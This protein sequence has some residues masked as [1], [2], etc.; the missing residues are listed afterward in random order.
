MGLQARLCRSSIVAEF[1]ESGVNCLQLFSNLIVVGVFAWHIL[2][3][4][5]LAL[6]QGILPAPQY[7]SL[8][9]LR[10]TR[11]QYITRMVKYGRWMP[12]CLIDISHN[13]ILNF[14]T[15]QYPRCKNCADNPNRFQG[16][17]ARSC[18]GKISEIENFA[19]A[20]N[21]YQEFQRIPL[22]K[23][24]YHAPCVLARLLHHPA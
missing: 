8:R 20:S 17:D 1:L 23:E 6:L 19:T 18:A 10:K 21:F 16:S 4:C 13:Q 22:K 7:F 14:A 11:A 2:G 5:D 24:Q 15:S 3:G 12:Y 9:T